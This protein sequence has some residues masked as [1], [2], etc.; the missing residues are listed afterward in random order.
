MLSSKKRKEDTPISV[1]K[2]TKLTQTDLWKECKSFDDLWQKEEEAVKE[3]RRMLRIRGI[4][5]ESGIIPLYKQRVK[6]VDA[7]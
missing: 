7:A 1:K 5:Y 2:L 4:K 6:E 3:F